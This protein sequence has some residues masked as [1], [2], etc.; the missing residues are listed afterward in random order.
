M[1]FFELIVES[2]NV[3]CI[4]KSVVV[5]VVVLKIAF[6]MVVDAL[7]IRLSIRFH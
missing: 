4:F 7:F 2:M 1:L 3:V 6:P 5:V